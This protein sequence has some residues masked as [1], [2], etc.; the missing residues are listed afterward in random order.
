MLRIVAEAGFFATLYATAAVL[1]EG[2][3][4][5]IGPTEFILL[6][7]LGALI[8][9]FA[10][11]RPELGAPALIIAVLGGGIACW[12]A[13]PIARGL[14]PG[15]FG[16][17][18][19]THGIGWIGAFAVLRGSFI[20]GG[21]SDA[22]QLE[23]L[24]RGLLPFVA[25]LWAVTSLFVAKALW[26]LFAAY[27]LWGTLALIVA[28]LAGIGLVRLRVLHAG[29]SETRVRRLW[30][31]LVLAA[32]I[33]VV[34][35]SVPFAVLAGVPVDVLPQPLAGPVLFLIGLFAIPIGFLIDSL[36][37]LLTPIASSLG[38]FLDELRDRILGQQR[39]KLEPVEPSIVTTLIGLAIAA[40]VIAV[41][42]SAMYAL[43]RWLLSRQEDPE[44]GKSPLE[45]IVEH[46]IVVPA[47]FP[48]RPR[49]A[50]RHR[51]GAAH[52][53]VG[54]YVSAID[55][56]AAHPSWSRDPAETPAEHSFRVREADMPGSPEFSRLAADY[57]LAR[58]A[59]RPITRREDR[60][61][62]SRLDRFRRLIKARGGPIPRT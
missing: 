37:T 50:A 51:R 44:P 35:L 60:R 2:S 30:R 21:T 55:E 52:D 62:L 28:G 10:E 56:L 1:L 38:K 42:L 41:L 18:V 33:S 49:P 29:V 3:V 47:P 36:V 14:L 39:P 46:A 57:Q 22:H 26:P 13:S 11:D 31:W 58:Y 59:E 45:G 34:P 61:A 53:A 16:A 27:A 6:V 19:V 17:A 20:R 7:G 40:V 54:A 32:A 15:H 5:L 8:G 9:H 48:A 43:A 23:Q 24:L 25:V 12:L 4:P